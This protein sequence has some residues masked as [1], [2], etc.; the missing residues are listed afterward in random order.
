MQTNKVRHEARSETISVYKAALNV[1][2]CADLGNGT[3]AIPISTTEAKVVQTLTSEA[4]TA[5][6]AEYE[7]KSRYQTHNDIQKRGQLP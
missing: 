2:G 6:E 1:S 4:N 7:Y 5:T 3:K